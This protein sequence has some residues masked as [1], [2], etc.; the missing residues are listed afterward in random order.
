MTGIGKRRVRNVL[1]FFP[2]VLLITFLSFA[3][4]YFSPGDAGRILLREHL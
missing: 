2:M 1:L 4:V 3:V